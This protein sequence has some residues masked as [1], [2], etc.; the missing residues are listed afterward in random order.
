M[1]RFDGRGKAW[2]L[3]RIACGEG[4]ERAAGRT[5][6]PSTTLR[7]GRDDKGRGVAQVGVVSGMGSAKAGLSCPPK[8]I[9]TALI[10]CRPCG[11]YI[12]FCAF[13]RSLLSPG[14][15]EVSV[16]AHDHSRHSPATH[17][18]STAKRNGAILPFPTGWLHTIWI[19]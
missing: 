4:F 7:S 3:I 17:R 13:F 1:Q 5:A 11:T 16:K 19:E 12:C 2:W 6:D 9:W 14:F 15:F 8:L 18:F 10:F